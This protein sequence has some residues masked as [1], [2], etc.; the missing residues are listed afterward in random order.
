MTKKRRNNGAQKGHSLMHPI[1]CTC[2]PKDK[3]IKKFI[4][5]NMVE[6]AAIRDTSEASV[7]DAY[8]LPNCMWNYITMWVVPFTARESV[9][10]LRKPGKTGHLNPDLDLRVLPHVL[11]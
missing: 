6:A 9:I 5:Q 10:T 7:F 3:A 1:R 2:M 8:L 4:I 11:D